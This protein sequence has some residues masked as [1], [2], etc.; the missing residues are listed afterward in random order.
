MPSPFRVADQ[1]PELSSSLGVEAG[2][3]LV[4]EQ[5]LR[6]PD[7]AEGYVQPSTLAPGQGGAPGSVGFSSR[8]TAAMDLVRGARVR[9]S[10]VCEVSN[11]L[12]RRSGRARWPRESCRTMPM[13]V[14]PLLRRL[15]RGRWPRTRTVP[16]SRRRSPS[17]I[18]T[19]VVLPAP[20]GT[21]E[22]EHLARRTSRST[23]STARCRVPSLRGA[24]RAD[25]P[26]HG[27]RQ[28]SHHRRRS[29][30]PI[31]RRCAWLAGRASF[32]VAGQPSS[33]S[34]TRMTP[35]GR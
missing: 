1:G 20:F 32:D 19:V 4:E 21:E 34:Q 27:D 31:M 9:G 18:S 7:D 12:L 23:E 10:R 15:G 25:Q 8:P 22:G 2:G 28:L 35:A 16:A 6:P 29:S 24:V 17:R 13:R 11:D 14:L 30:R 26:A 3:R 5:Q 33:P